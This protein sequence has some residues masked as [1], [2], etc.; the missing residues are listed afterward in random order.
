MPP[1]TEAT[2]AAVD[3]STPEMAATVDWAILFGEVDWT[4]E[5][6]VLVPISV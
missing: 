3:A 1:P 5:A 4:I 2:G 6:G